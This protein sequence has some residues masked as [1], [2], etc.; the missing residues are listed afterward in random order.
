MPRAVAPPAALPYAEHDRV[1]PAVDDDDL[2]LCVRTV[3]FAEY[4]PERVQLE[5][6]RRAFEAVCNELDDYLPF[7]DFLRKVR[8]QWLWQRPPVPRGLVDL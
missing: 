3:L 7:K 6:A 1:F 4:G 5:H 2:W 8:L